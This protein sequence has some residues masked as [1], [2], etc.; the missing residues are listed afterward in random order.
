MRIL[1]WHVHGSWTTSFVQGRHTYLVP[2]TSDRGPDGLGRARTYA[3]PDSVLEVAPDQLRREDVDVVVLQRPHEAGLAEGWLGRRPGRDVPAVYVEHNTPKGEILAARHPV[4]DRDD[5]VLVHVT[6]FNRLFWDNGRAPTTVIEHG[7]VD[8]GPH[9]T[10]ELPHAGIAINEPIRRWRVTGTDL[11]PA[12]ADAAPLD[13]FGMQ[14]E[15]LGE[16]LGLG[17][18]RLAT[19]DLPQGQLHEQLARRRVYVHPLRWTS[20]G[21]SLL[22]AM[23]LAMPVVVLASTEAI[24]AVPPDAGVI[25]TQLDV[26]RTAIRDYVGDP[27]RAREMGQRARRSVLARYSLDRFT[28]DWDLLLKEVTR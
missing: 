27:D 1:L 8:P 15:E 18:D 5:V 20:L 19:Y 14:T 23:H 11:L 25:S 4:A 16:R 24:E 7:V 10:G 17:P 2:V 26:L 28:N 6:H 9:Y 21:L 13:V 12:L 22:E 3:W